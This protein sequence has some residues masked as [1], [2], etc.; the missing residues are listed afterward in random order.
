M[1]KLDFIELVAPIVVKV[2]KEK[3]FP[4]YS[5]VVIAQA[6]LETGWGNSEIMMKANAIFG[7]K[8]TTNWKGKVYDYITEECY[9]NINFTKINACFRAYDSI[10]KSIKDYF[11]LILT[12]NRYKN[13]INTK[14]ALECITAIKNGGYATD[15]QYVNKIMII[16]DQNDLQKYDEIETIRNEYYEK[17]KTYITQ[18]DLN[19]RRGAGIEY[20]IKNR[21]ELTQDGIKH[22]Y[23]QDLG[24]IKKGTKVTAL[25]VIIDSNKN[26]WLRIPS[27]YI[28]AIF[29][30]KEYIL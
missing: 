22:S 7:I 29:Y 17:G 18:V 27:G 21:K 4:L 30:G 11:E 1:N 10:E 12:L 28:C 2:N 14:S 19:V 9:D 23:N 13:A 8:A 15:P 5:S 16:I 20:P 26:I 3:G 24:V 6:I 25:E